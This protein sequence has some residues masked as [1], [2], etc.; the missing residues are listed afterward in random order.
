MLEEIEAEKRVDSDLINRY[1]LQNLASN[2]LY[3]HAKNVYGN[4]DKDHIKRLNWHRTTVCKR[5]NIGQVQIHKSK[6]HGKTFYGGLQTCGSVWACPV[7]ANKIQARR[8]LEIRKAFKWAYKEELHQIMMVTFTYS[9]GISDKLFETMK[10]HTLA[11]KKFREH[12]DY[13]TLM[14]EIGYKG[15]I[16][17]LEL[18][19]GGSGWHPH[20][21]EL[22]VINPLV[23]EKDIK[24]RILALWQKICTSVGLLDKDNEKQIKAFQKHSVDIVFNA[25]DSDYIAKQNGGNDKCWGADREMARAS[26][27]KGK[28]TGKS[29]F[30]LLSES[31]KDSTYKELFVEYAMAM[32][33]KAQLFWSR[34]LKAK[35]GVDEKTDEQLAEEQTDTADTLALLSSEHWKKVLS[36]DNDSKKVR[37]ELLIIARKEGFEGIRKWF[38]DYGLEIQPPQLD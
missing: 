37:A 34:G 38:A 5:V 27:K 3:N 24:R 19:Y 6:K 30:Q 21:H 13:T 26:S 31:E 15:L 14:K 4:D 23:D 32:K 2:I 36:L 33:G 22:F 11:M 28:K 7:C 16:R 35:V 9:H 20:T 8:T 1:Y 10:K 25:K 12:R 17:S 18:T 29:P